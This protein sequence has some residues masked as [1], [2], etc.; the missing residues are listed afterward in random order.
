MIIQVFNT[1]RE[2][3]LPQKKLARLVKYI[4][5]SENKKFEV[6]VI[7]TGSRK[8]QSL[9]KTYRGQDKPTDVLSFVPEENEEP[10]PFKPL[11]EIYVSVPVARR[12]AKQAGH[13]LTRELL[14]LTSHGCLHLCG[15]THETD[16]KY[17]AM[18]T[19]SEK[20]LKRSGY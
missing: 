5:V 7:L 12:Q 18:M 6:N 3:Y 16:A 19:A 13:S 20:A 17:S 15:Y 14:F 1:T 9:N 11:G 8:I 10:P 2:K 4:L